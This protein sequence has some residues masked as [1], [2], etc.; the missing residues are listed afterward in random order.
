MLLRLPGAHRSCARACQG[1]RHQGWPTPLRL[2]RLLHAA[3]VRAP[4]LP[5]VSASRKCRSSRWSLQNSPI[6][7]P[8]EQARSPPSGPGRRQILGAEGTD[9]Q[10]AAS[11]IGQRAGPGRQDAG[12]NSRRLAESVHPQAGDSIRNRWEGDQGTIPRV[13]LHRV[14][15]SVKDRGHDGPGIFAVEWVALMPKVVRSRRRITMR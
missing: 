1:Q 12:D 9:H 5:A 11:Q 10:V 8:R 6:R 15:R 13:G 14:T 2:R 3:L 4:A 7:C